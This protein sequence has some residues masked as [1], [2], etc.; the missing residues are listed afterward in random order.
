VKKVYSA[1]E[2]VLSYVALYVWREHVG[3]VAACGQF[4]SYF[5]AAYVDQGRFDD[6]LAEFLDAVESPCLPESGKIRRLAARSVHCG[7]ITFVDQLFD[8][9]PVWQFVDGV[10]AG[11]PV[12]RCFGSILCVE[13]SDGFNG[14]TRRRFIE[15]VI[16]QLKQF[17]VFDSKGYHCHSVAVTCHGKKHFQGRSFCGY[18]NDF[19]RA[20]LFERAGSDGSVTEMN[21]IERSTEQDYFSLSHRN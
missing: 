17:I 14:I 9:V 10:G 3:D 13:V 20:E 2:V 15:F 1:V 5:G 11:E 7:K 18:E 19:L 21:G 4:V 8:F 16:T 6:I 12:D